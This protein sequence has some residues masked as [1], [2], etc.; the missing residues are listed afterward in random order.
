LKPSTAVPDVCFAPAHAQDFRVIVR[1][2]SESPLATTT[3]RAEFHI[4]SCIAATLSARMKMN[5]AGNVVIACI[6]YR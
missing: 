6:S 1:R 2:K 5:R 3:I 4:G